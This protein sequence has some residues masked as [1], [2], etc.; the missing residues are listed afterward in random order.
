MWR[1]DDVLSVTGRSVPLRFPPVMVMLWQALQASIT[2]SS[3]QGAV[4]PAQEAACVSDG[5]SSTED[6]APETNKKPISATRHIHCAFIVALE[7]ETWWKE[8]VDAGRAQA[9]AADEASARKN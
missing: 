9:R 7:V 1:F 5:V 4:P 3:A 8:L 6:S 2:G